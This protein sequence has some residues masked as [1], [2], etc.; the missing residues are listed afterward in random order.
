MRPTVAATTHFEPFLTDAQHI[1]AATDLHAATALHATAI[2]ALCRARTGPSRGDVARCCAVSPPPAFTPLASYVPR[3]PPP[4][5]WSPANAATAA[6]DTSL[7]LMRGDR[8]S[9]GGA[10]PPPDS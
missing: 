5:T 8:R 10:P 4:S 9:A 2:R 1:A 6:P 7:P 3:R